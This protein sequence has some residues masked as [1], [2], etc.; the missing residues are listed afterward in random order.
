MASGKLLRQL[1]KSGVNKDENGFRQISEALIAEERQKHHNLLAND[2]EKILYG[3]NSN[4]NAKNIL[5]FNVK[6]NIPHDK[7]RGLPLLEI[8][9]PV[10]RLEDV[11]LSNENKENIKRILKEY[12]REEILRTWGM[13]P[14]ERV[15][16]CGPP[17]CGK[18][19]S[20]EA[21]AYE[22]NRPL[23]IIRLDSVV[24]SYL[25][26]TSANL[27]KVFDFIQTSPVVALFDE[28]DALGKERSDVAEHGEL[29]RVVNTFL[30]M[31]DGFEGQS[32]II[33][34]TNHE[35]M[36]DSAIWRRFEDVLAFTY[37]TVLQIKNLLSLKLRGVRR[38]FEFSK[39][40]IDLFK[41]ISHA[42]IERILKRSIKDMLLDGE[43]FLKFEHID[44][45]F[46]NE[47]AR[48]KSLLKSINNK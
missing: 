27:R 17:G 45:A 41:N 46:K 21:L 15:L 35:S 43:E 1:I 32:L 31:L 4:K 30:Q 40:V 25:G 19:I 24:S 14:V 48:K 37:P 36:L 5:S 12:N 23:C 26:E 2:L 9:E 7:E 39:T 20:A 3:L 22:L 29:K 47:K 28:F 16:F 34:A 8:K 42:D 13:R 38:E 11:V 18:T 10:R 6:Q 44:N 33:A